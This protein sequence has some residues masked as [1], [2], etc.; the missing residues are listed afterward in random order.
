MSTMQSVEFD[1]LTT[2]QLKEARDALC[3]LSNALTEGW[4]I[5]PPRRHPD[6]E[7]LSVIYSD[8]RLRNL[9]KARQQLMVEELSLLTMRLISKRG[10]LYRSERKRETAREKK[11]VEDQG[12]REKRVVVTLMYMNVTLTCIDK[13]TAGRHSLLRLFPPS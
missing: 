12:G 3:Q 4:P 2:P 1:Y 9:N 5:C 8:F 6:Y 7:R 13:D 11:R 10:E